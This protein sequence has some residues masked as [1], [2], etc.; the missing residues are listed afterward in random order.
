MYL[1]RC[2]ICYVYH[3]LYIFEQYNFGICIWLLNDTC[4]ICLPKKGQPRYGN[5]LNLHVTSLMN[6]LG[7]NS[8]EL[9]CDALESGHCSERYLRFFFFFFFFFCFFFTATILT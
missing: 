1:V 4:Y 7:R 2:Y 6:E 9:H 8:F 5:Q 3:F